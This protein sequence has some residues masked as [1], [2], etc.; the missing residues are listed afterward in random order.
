MALRCL[1]LA[2]LVLATARPRQ[3]D[4]SSRVEVEG[5]DI[6]LALDVSGSMQLFDDLG[7]RRSRFEVA[8]REALTFVQ[9]R[10]HD[11][12]GLV[13]F[14]ATAISRCP[15]TLDKQ[16]LHEIITNVA[17]GE[18]NPEGTALAVGLGMAVNRLR[19]SKSTS[20]IIILLT[21]GE[22]SSHDIDP[23][24]ILNLAKK[25]GIKIYTIGVGSDQGGYGVVPIHGVVQFKTPINAKLLQK[26]ADQT[27]GQFF[28]AENPEE[29]RQ[30]YKAIDKLE[31]TSYDTP[32]YARYH[33]LF[34]VFLYSALCFIGLE[35]L[36]RWWLVIL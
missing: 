30:V 19:T 27:G 31:K 12:I 4:D 18:V 22:P 25:Y 36:L 28:R 1:A 8:Q 34:L 3:A 20:K 29:V 5:S 17:L 2:S 32:L 21:D 24:P 26:I 33:E 9:D 35:L 16:L 7:D 11:P 6:I 15:V 10:K 23:E 14:G 13:I